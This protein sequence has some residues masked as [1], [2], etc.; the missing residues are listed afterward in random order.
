[1]K[2]NEP[3]ILRPKRSELLRKNVPFIAA[4]RPFIAW[5]EITAEVNKQLVGYCFAPISTEALRGFF[6]RDIN[7][8]TGC[9]N[10]LPLLIPHKT[11]MPES[12][13]LEPWARV[14]V[15]D[16]IRLAAKS[17]NNIKE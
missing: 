8:S 16:K 12:A 2:T 13:P 11:S 14:N 1:M 5:A 17:V 6:N 9:L 3:T 15:L 10:P 4:S 7:N